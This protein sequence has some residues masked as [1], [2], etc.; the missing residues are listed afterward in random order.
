MENLLAFV[1][2]LVYG[3]GGSMISTGGET[4][5]HWGQIGIGTHLQYQIHANDNVEQE[6]T[7]E[8]P[9]TCNRKEICLKF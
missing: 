6:M 9:E 1:R 8:Q 7:M 5:W 2:F 4:W 3:Y